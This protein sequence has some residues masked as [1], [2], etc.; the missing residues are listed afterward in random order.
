MNGGGADFSDPMTSE[1]DKNDR[2]VNS[3]RA[4][5]MSSSPWLLSVEYDVG[6]ENE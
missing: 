3:L 6:Q 2:S 4:R 5:T 1:K